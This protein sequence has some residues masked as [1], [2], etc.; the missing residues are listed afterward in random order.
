MTTTTAIELPIDFNTMDETGLPWTFLDQ[1][2]DPSRVVPGAHLVAGSGTVHAVVVVV[3]VTDDGIVHVCD[4]P[5]SV[6]DNA[7]LLGD[8][9]VFVPASERL[10]DRLPDP[11]EAGGTGRD[12][13]APPE[14]ENPAT[15]RGNGTRRHRPARGSST[16]NPKVAGSNPAPATIDTEISGEAGP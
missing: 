9:S 13:T 8:R 4:V 6:E 11:V 2:V 3:D 16:H 5:G 10:P 15:P 14:A 7:H 1:A 12:E